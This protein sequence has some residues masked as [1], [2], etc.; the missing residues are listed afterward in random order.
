M[1]LA[2]QLDQS[3]FD[4][5]RQA[6]LDLAERGRTLTPML[7]SIGQGLEASTRERFAETSQ[8]P[9]GTPWTPSLASVIEGR[10]TLV[11]S[12]NLSD[13]I[14]HAVAGNELDVG[15]NVLYAAVHQRGATIKAKQS[16]GLRFRIGDQWVTKQQV[17]IP[18]RPFI[19][20]S[21]DDDEMI[22]GEATDFLA[23]AFA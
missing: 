20:L 11:A 13:S 21:A 12:G 16:G 4:R 19:G 18:A 9:D 14:T 5:Y 8:A 6:L 10:R 22:V 23:G 7:D 3:Q 17:E 2:I 15:T 1:R